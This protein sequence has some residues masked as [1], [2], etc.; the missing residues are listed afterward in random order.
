MPSQVEICRLA[1]S[2][3]ADAARVNSI[4]PPDNTVQAQHCATFY[5]IARDELLE[6]F[7]W[8]FATRRV[9]LSLSAVEFDDGEWAYAYLLPSNFI[10]AIKVVPPGASQDHPGYDYRM[11]SDVTELD[12]ILLSNVEEAVLH[13]VYREEETGRYTPLFISALSHLLASYLAGPIIKGG[14]GMRAKQAMYEIYLDL[15]NKAMAADANSAQLSYQY[16]SYKPTW[17]TDR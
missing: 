8:T 16:T 6:R 17:V 14:A 13:Y 10:R 15:A 3:I 4:D 7:N 11:E 1:L 5:P 12:L 9:A 2:H